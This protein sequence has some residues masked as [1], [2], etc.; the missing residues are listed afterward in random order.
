MKEYNLVPNERC[1]IENIDQIKICADF[2]LKWLKEFLEKKE[3]KGYLMI[4]E[5]ENNEKK[6]EKNL[7]SSNID[8]KEKE[9]LKDD[10][11]DLKKKDEKIQ[12]NIQNLPLLYLIIIRIG[13][14]KNLIV[15][16]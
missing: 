11:D 1:S 6:E 7:E 16:N 10:D 14:I 2:A 8:I 13:N 4:Q 5:D 12:E 15:L 9:N 3:F